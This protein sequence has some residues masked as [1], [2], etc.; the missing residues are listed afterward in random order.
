MMRAPLP[1]MFVGLCMLALAGVAMAVPHGTVK[2]D[3]P[4]TKKKPVAT[5]SAASTKKVAKLPGHLSN[6]V[7][8][9]IEGDSIIPSSKTVIVKVNPTKRKA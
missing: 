9:Q 4:P 8:L 6:F 2:K 5:K 3:V 1:V 7:M